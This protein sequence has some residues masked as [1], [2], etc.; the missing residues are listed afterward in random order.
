LY[1]EILI[2]KNAVYFQVHGAAARSRGRVGTDTP[3]DHTTTKFILV[4][5]HELMKHSVYP[6]Y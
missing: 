2:I 1:Y 6:N 4:N 5:Y 3:C